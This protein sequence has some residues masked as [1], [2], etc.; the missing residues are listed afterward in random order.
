MQG[1]P[2]MPLFVLM[3]CRIFKS[4]TS[5]FILERMDLV[6]LGFKCMRGCGGGGVGVIESQERW[7]GP[8]LCLSLRM[9]VRL[10]C[11]Q[12]VIGGSRERIV[13]AITGT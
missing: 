2:V 8:L 7:V 1:R 6:L 11:F 10:W 13:V 5:S 12:G 3:F 9:D 4:S